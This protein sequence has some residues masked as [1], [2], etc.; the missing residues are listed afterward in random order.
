MAAG[1]TATISVERFRADWLDHTPIVQLCEQYSITKDQ[2]I[3]LRDVWAL[4]LRHDRKLRSKPKRQRDP[5][6][7]EIELA[8]LRIQATW[9]ERTRELRAVAKTSHVTLRQV[10]LGDVDTSSAEDEP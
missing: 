4:P 10:S 5:T 2:V 7:S 3:R 1:N 9:D 6:Q 8:C